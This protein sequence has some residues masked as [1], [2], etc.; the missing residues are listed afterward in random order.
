MSK[1]SK[2]QHRAIRQYPSTKIIVE[3]TVTHGLFSNERKSIVL[4]RVADEVADHT[5]VA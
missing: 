4:S 5:G 2:A 3:R 1:D